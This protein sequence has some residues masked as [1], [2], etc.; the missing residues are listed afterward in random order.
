MRADADTPD[1][2]KTL[3]AQLSHWLAEAHELRLS[4]ADPART[5][6]RPRLRE[7]QAAR[8][9][10]THADLLA[11]SRY[12]QAARFFLTDLYSPKDLSTRDAEIERVLPVMTSALPRSALHALLQAAELDALSERFDGQLID[13]LAGRLDAPLAEADYADAYRQVGNAPGRQRQIELIQAIGTTLDHLAHKP[14]LVTLLRMMRRPA[15]AAGLGELQA[16]LERGFT[17][18]RSMERADEFVATVVARERALSRALFDG[19]PS[20]ALPADQGATAHPA[21]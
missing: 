20:L 13:A 18:F 21:P 19:A 9:T 7:F 15:Q 10:H 17:A 16:F 3:A 6:R 1:D 2:R 8:L 14:G 12:E 5:P 4:A 11:S